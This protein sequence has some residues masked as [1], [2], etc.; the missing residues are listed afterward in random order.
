MDS[1]SQP[2]DRVTEAVEHFVRTPSLRCLYITTSQMLRLVVLETVTRGELLEVNTTP[3]FVLEAPTEPGDDGFSLRSDELRLDWRL[4]AESDPEQRM[5]PL[6]PEEEARAPLARFGLEL[7]RAIGQ[8][9]PPM[10]GLTIVLAPVWVTDAVAFRAGLETLL[11]QRGLSR[12]RFIVVETD[13]RHALALRDDAEL[14]RAIEHVAAEMDESLLEAEARARLEAMKSAPTSARG[15]RRAGAAGPDVPPPRR[16]REPTPL[17]PEAAQAEASAL[18][19]P[20]AYLQPELLHELQVFVMSAALAAREK[21]YPE[22]VR[23][24]REAR[25][26]AD[27]LQLFREALIYELVLGGYLLQG[28]SAER[29]LEIFGNAERRAE[30]QNLLDQ[31]I[32]AIMASAATLVL[33]RRIDEAALRYAEAGS[34][35]EHL[36]PPVLAIEAFR[37][38]GQLAAGRG[39]LE[40]AATAF[41]RALA[42]AEASPGIGA[43]TSAPEAARELA[44][45]CRKH[46]LLAQAQS[47]EAQAESLETQPIE[48]QGDLEEAD[49]TPAAP[50]RPHTPTDEER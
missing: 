11:R 44:A 18:G 12:V 50:A 21:N 41:R 32:Q 13:T 28:G 27:Q 33:L 10:T 20:A 17:S 14:S 23:L 48:A 46:G 49:P 5:K 19:I 16:I 31:R 36:K 1:L 25:D 40:Q 22:A 24:Q 39:H 3:F 43:L 30:A 35:G 26:R 47:L 6:W 2:L 42:A 29:A 8:L 37:M 4:L 34:L 45:L 38:C 15:L 7:G 9:M